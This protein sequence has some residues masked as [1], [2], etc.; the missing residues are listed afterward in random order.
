MRKARRERERRRRTRERLGGNERGLEGA[1]V[2]T[3]SRD[4]EYARRVGQKESNN[5]NQHPKIINN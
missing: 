2:G 4:R 1:R 5:S 3:E